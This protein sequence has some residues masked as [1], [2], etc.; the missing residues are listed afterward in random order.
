[1][2]F[3]KTRGRIFAFCVLYDPLHTLTD[4]SWNQLTSDVGEAKALRL[5]RAVGLRVEIEPHTPSGGE[6]GRRELGAAQPGLPV[7]GGSQHEPVS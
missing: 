6:E 2:S 1:M 7:P 5:P 3:L 4:P